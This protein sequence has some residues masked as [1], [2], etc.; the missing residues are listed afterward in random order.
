MC[1]LQEAHLPARDIH[2]CQVK[3][4]FQSSSKQMLKAKPVH[5]FYYLT[6]ETLS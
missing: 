1:C 2:R 3:W 4:W 5:L 6:T